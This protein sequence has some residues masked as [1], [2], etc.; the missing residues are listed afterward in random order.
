MIALAKKTRR[1]SSSSIHSSRSRVRRPT[2]QPQG[3]PTTKST[4]QHVQFTT[5]Y[6]SDEEEDDDGTTVHQKPSE[7]VESPRLH[8]DIPHQLHHISPTPTPVIHYPS[9]A[10][11][12][13]KEGLSSSSAPKFLQKS[14]SQ[15][16][17]VPPEVFITNVVSNDLVRPSTSVEHIFQDGAAQSTPTSEPTV[18]PS[19][20]PVSRFISSTPPGRSPKTPDLDMTNATIGF[21]RYQ[22]ATSLARTSQDHTIPLTS[23]SQRK[24][25]RTQQK[26][27]LQKASTQPPIHPLTPTT[28]A[29][30]PALQQTS[31]REVSIPDYFSPLPSTTQAR[32]SPGI[33]VNIPYDVKVAREFERISRELS[34][35]RKFGDPTADAIAR[36]RYRIKPATSNTTTTKKGFTKKQSAYGFGMSSK[37]SPDKLDSRTSRKGNAVDDNVAGGEKRSKV[38]DVMKKLWFDEADV[39]DV[40]GLGTDDDDDDDANVRRSR[41]GRASDRS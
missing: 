31:M 18:T 12:A 2:S 24:L 33:Q 1:S 20:N 6:S 35:A 16:T 9:S 27:L 36:L 29:S 10:K 15:A 39:V 5:R 26:L 25:T 41:V 38:R 4:K 40:V 13:L 21:G 34:N 30:S 28:Y 32:L 11:S 17:L 37:P 8:H 19:S 23:V 22:S 7:I 14:L 3:H